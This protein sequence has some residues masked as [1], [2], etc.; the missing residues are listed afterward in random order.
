MSWSRVSRL[1]I[2][3]TVLI[4]S[5]AAAQTGPAN[6]ALVD[7]AATNDMAARAKEISE[8][9]FTYSYT[10]LKGHETRF[11][12]L[13]TGEFSDKY[14]ELFASVGSQANA[15][16][17]NVTSTVKDAAVRL[18]TDDRAEVL[19][20]IDQ[21]STRG[22]TGQTNTAGS[23]FLATLARVDGDWKVSDIDLFE[24]DE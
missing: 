10:D 3:L 5:P 12:D 21:S 18:L 17:L 11:K 20:F 7:T 2:A 15:M 22:D 23:M 4:A 16:Q 13:T 9:L 19:V 6:R 24:G 14:A 8:Q 1:V